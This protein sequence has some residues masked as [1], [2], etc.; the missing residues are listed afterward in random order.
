MTILLTRMAVFLTSIA[1]GAAGRWIYFHPER[2][3]DRFYGDLAP[4]PSSKLSLRVMKFFGAIVLF[5]GAGAATSQ[6]MLVF[7]QV[8]GIPASDVFAV[9]LAGLAGIGTLYLLRTP[10]S[11]HEGKP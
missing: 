5:V 6:L 2:C 7:F 9:S 3:L 4:K 8:L 1:F 10:S 11:R